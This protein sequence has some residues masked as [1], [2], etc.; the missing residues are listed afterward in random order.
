MPGGQIETTFVET[1]V[2]M[3]GLCANADFFVVVLSSCEGSKLNFEDDRLCDLDIHHDSQI[4][5]HV[6]GGDCGGLA[7][8]KKEGKI[9]KPLKFN[10]SKQKRFDDYI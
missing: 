2:G 8:L 5:A 6:I 1:S 10:G 7:E 9:L 4:D 3:G